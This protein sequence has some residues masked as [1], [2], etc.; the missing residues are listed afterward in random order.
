MTVGTPLA[1]WLLQTDLVSLANGSSHSEEKL[2][3]TTA[4]ISQPDTASNRTFCA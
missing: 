2:N 1:V 3:P 4:A